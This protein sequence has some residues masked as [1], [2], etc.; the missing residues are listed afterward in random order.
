[1]G[2]SHCGGY[3]A[4]MPRSNACIYESAA[5]SFKP[6]TGRVGTADGQ[7]VRLGPVNMKVL[8][9][10]L[11]R[12]L[13]VVTR[14]ELF[15]AVWR[16]QVVGEDALTRCISDI[17]A[18]LRELS[19]RTDLIETLPRRG[20]RWTESVRESAA[21]PGRA[22][23]AT[24]HNTGSHADVGTAGSRS[25]VLRALGKGVV[26]LIALAAMGSLLVWSIDRIAGPRLPVVAVLPIAAH[27]ADRVLADRLELALTDHLMQLSQISVLSRSAVAT[28]PDNPF[29]Y[30]YFEFGARW[31]IE[32]EV[33]ESYGKP[34]LTMA[35]VD[36]RT[37]I[38]LMRVTEPIMESDTP[39]E[40]RLDRALERLDGA[41]ADELGLR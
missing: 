16:N 40:T 5:L 35:L 6:E 23:E 34:T 31:L 8:A 30:F 32:S 20:Y 24:A 17:R 36:A 41:I 11:G 27:P 14:A 13:Q 12:P 25:R 10:L 18:A 26:W 28:R 29:P 19:G 38:S 3:T 37:G 15:D 21:S 1:M 9:V 39:S 33:R 7:S 4:R 2:L 22:S